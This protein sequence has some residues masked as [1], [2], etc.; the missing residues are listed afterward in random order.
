MNKS[1]LEYLIDYLHALTQIKSED[2]S[3]LMWA[4]DK[5]VAIIEQIEEEINKL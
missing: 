3:M 2:G 4:N 1:K 5:A